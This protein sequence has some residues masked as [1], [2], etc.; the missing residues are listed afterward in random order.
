MYL[1]VTHLDYDKDIVPFIRNG[2]IIDTSIIDI[3]VNGLVLTRISRKESKD[4]PEYDA[5]L[6]FLDLIKM[7]N[8]WDKFVIT[9]HILTEVC[10]HFRK[11]YNKRPD[12]SNIVEEVFPFIMNMDEQLVTKR[13]IMSCI[14][15]KKPIIEI[16]DISINIV[17]NN[18]ISATEKTAILA[19]DRLLNGEYKDNPNVLVMDY[20]SIV[21]NLL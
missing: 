5:L 11:T 18:F 17:A 21:L 1:D 13:D 9:P 2:I 10:T 19:K 6:L 15:F 4:L 12:Y 8:K 7:S 20:E 3:I 16:G 14:N